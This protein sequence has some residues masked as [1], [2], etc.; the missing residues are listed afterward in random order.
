[1]VDISEKAESTRTAIAEGFICMSA[2]V[3]AQVEQQAMA[4]G[5]VL[6][7]A[8]I[9]GIQGAKRCADLIPLC[10]PLALNKVAI[11]FEIDREN[12]RIR[13]ESLC[14]V[15]GKT[16]VEMEA[17]TAVSTAALTIFDMCKALGLNMSIEGIRV[18]DKKG[19]KSGHWSH[20]AT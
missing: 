4:K 10:H 13:I 15:T 2:D 18:L 12:N 6:S 17:L 3:L 5:D 9:A 14:R 11:E 1:M 20:Q 8:R 7:V 16:G 19:G